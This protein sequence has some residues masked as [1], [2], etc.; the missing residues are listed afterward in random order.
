MPPPPA[1]AGP[2]APAPMPPPPAKA[3]PPAPAP[4]PPP[5]PPPPPAAKS[6]PTPVASSGATTGSLAS[7]SKLHDADDDVAPLAEANK[8]PSQRVLKPSSTAAEASAV[9]PP[10]RTCNNVLI[11]RKEPNRSSQAS[12]VSQIEMAA[13]LRRDTV[14]GTIVAETIDGVEVEA[15]EVDIVPFDFEDALASLH[16]M[17]MLPS[18]SP[19]AV[20]Y[21]VYQRYKSNLHYTL[22][23]DMLVSVNPYQWLRY[24]AN[25]P[26]PTTSIAER[27]VQ[28]LLRSPSPSSEAADTVLRSMMTNRATTTVLVTGLS[29]AGKTESAKMILKHVADRCCGASS[30]GNTSSLL[31]G[32]SSSSSADML[33]LL[34]AVD[35]ILE[36]FGNAPTAMNENSS[37][38]AKCVTLEVD[39]EASLLHGITVQSFLLETSRLINR[40]PDEG[41]FHV[42][43]ALFQS[44]KKLRL[45]LKKELELWDATQFQCLR[46]ASQ[47]GG[48][49]GRASSAVRV[50]SR[51]PYTL[52]ELVAAFELL[53]MDT[54]AIENVLRILAGILHLLNVEFAADDAY[55]A[56]RVVDSKPLATAARLFGLTDVPPALQ[57]RAGDSSAAASATTP[58]TSYL[59]RVL[60]SVPLGNEVKHLH[61]AA[62]M[63]TRDSLAKMIYE[64]LFSLLLGKLSRRKGVSAAGGVAA[65]TSP[66]VKVAPTIPQYGDNIRTLQLLDIFGFEQVHAPSKNDLEQLLINFTNEMLQGI[67]D[68]TTSTAYVNELER[69]GVQAAVRE[70]TL[71][72]A[73]TGDQQSPSSGPEGAAGG[74][75]ANNKCLEVLTKK[76]NGVLN[77]ISDDSTLAQ[78]NASQA[79]LLADKILALQ[80]VYPDVLKR[81]KVNPAA[82]QLA[83][84][85]DTVEYSTEKLGIK[86][87]MSSGVAYVMRTST[88]SLLRECHSVMNASSALKTSTNASLITLFREQ[89]D[90][91]QTDLRQS[92]L[93]WVRCVKPNAVRSPTDFDGPYVASQLASSG[94]YR[95]LQLQTEGYAVILTHEVFSRQYLLPFFSSKGLTTKPAAEQFFGH[96]NKAKFQAACQWACK[97]VPAC[98]NRKMFVGISKVFTKAQHL[99][100]LTSVAQKWKESASLTLQRIGRGFFG[101]RG[102]ATRRIEKIREQKV[103]E[104]RR[105]VEEEVPIR[106]ALELE[107]NQ[108]H[109]SHIGFAKSLSSTFSRHSQKRVGKLFHIVQ[110]QVTFISNDLQRGVEEILQHDQRRIA[111]ETHERERYEQL[112]AS[113][114]AAQATLDK[115]K[116]KREIANQ[117]RQ[118]ARQKEEARA[119]ERE[120]LRVVS[121]ADERRLKDEQAEIRRRQLRAE[122]ELRMRRL[123]RS[124]LGY[125]TSMLKEAQRHI[126]KQQIRGSVSAAAA[127]VPSPLLHD[128]QAST[129]TSGYRR[130]AEA[131][132]SQELLD[133]G[134]ATHDF[135]V[136]QDLWRLW[137]QSRSVHTT[138][139]R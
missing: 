63:A 139:Y 23:G 29:G 133:D 1:K 20:L 93:L 97:T 104:V 25:V 31:G 3:V 88:N 110:E 135:A 85:C 8:L 13:V 9:Q 64:S 111:K 43:H 132:R 121:E 78:Q 42:L 95:A 12:L 53:G 59:E 16:D 137:E 14:N 54:A 83:H 41:T 60:T 73:M 67:Y 52:D 99:A 90:R 72:P 15:K 17:S 46:I 109:K 35:P 94:V 124:Q 10:S 45:D 119:A 101:R 58:P 7:T 33:R 27:A 40:N 71:G 114:K 57:S 92:A 61:R 11:H 82:F 74:A 115:E 50:A 105:R 131:Y 80:R 66:A 2:P 77:V 79:A 86:N 19:P 107:R 56:A 127:A 81:N 49:G 91:L 138:S 38:F 36:L 44:S 125:E 112:V 6:P 118:L 69:E 89:I 47:G 103:E 129:E 84:Y 102:V 32:A 117:T 122:E 24:P 70:A 28:A 120:R 21:S 130:G 39:V 136:Q 62:A 48:E 5:P 30:T 128:H 96:Y 26:H 18:A 100:I 34:Q 106:Q 116:E 134:S 51:M 68:E 22:V 113:S 75:V 123:Q 126:V 98:Q 87:R 4:M 76:P 37:R 55:S 108:M 65:T